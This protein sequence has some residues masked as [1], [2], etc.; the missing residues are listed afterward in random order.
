M[1][2]RAAVTRVRCDRAAASGVCVTP[3]R[4]RSLY[5]GKAPVHVTRASA[6]SWTQCCADHLRG[7]SGPRTK[8]EDWASFSTKCR[9]RCGTRAPAPPRAEVL[10]GRNVYPGV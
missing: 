7:I 8:R 10:L 6:L 4:V 9:N 5:Q 3:V 1:A 2:F